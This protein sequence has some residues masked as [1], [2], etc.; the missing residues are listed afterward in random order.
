MM[1]FA[2]RGL[3]PARIAE[4]NDVR[5]LSTTSLVL[6]LVIELR[7]IRAATRAAPTI[8]AYTPSFYSVPFSIQKWYKRAGITRTT[9]ALIDQAGF[10]T[11][12]LWIGY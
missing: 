7:S 5:F 10:N 6:Y 9:P 11:G 2:R 3:V 1:R 4:G 12:F 8:L